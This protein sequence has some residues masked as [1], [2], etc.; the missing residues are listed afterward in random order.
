MFQ[1]LTIS[2][3]SL[4][5]YTNSQQQITITTEFDVFAQ[6]Q[7]KIVSL[8]KASAT[9]SSE[10]LN[11]AANLDVKSSGLGIN[12][13]WS[14]NA[15]L[16]RNTYSGEYNNKLKYHVGNSKYDN[17]LSGSASKE[18]LNLLL[19]VL[20]TDL[21][22]VS[23]KLS[24]SKDQ[25]VIDSEICSYDN[26]PVLAHLDIKNLNTLLFTIGYKSTFLL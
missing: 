3:N 6:P 24:I 19:K 4:S 25:Q 13:E 15:K 17:V 23:S 10:G 20:N 26:S 16:N 8:Y 11:S 5:E 21:I 22:K 2:L 1:V 12:I 9:V 14:E 18:Q 7:Q